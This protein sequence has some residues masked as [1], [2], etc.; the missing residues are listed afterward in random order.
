MAL[1][2]MTILFML[3]ERIAHK[4]TC[5]FLPCADIEELLTHLLPLRDLT[6]KE[7]IFQLEQ[8]HHQRQR[9]IE[10]HTCPQQEMLK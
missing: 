5:P 10:C 6:E 9:A 4:E 2:M 7:V 3:S 8:R 1:V